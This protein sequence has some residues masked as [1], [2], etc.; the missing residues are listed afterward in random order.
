MYTVGY[1][2]KAQ[3]AV[4]WLGVVRGGAIE[5]ILLHR[6]LVHRIWS[7]PIRIRHY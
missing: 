2:V 6:F 3:G 5:Q 4:A 1:E 7:I